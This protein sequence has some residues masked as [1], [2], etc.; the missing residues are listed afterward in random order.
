MHDEHGEGDMHPPSVE[1]FRSFLLSTWGRTAFLTLTLAGRPVAIAVSDM[2]PDGLSAI[3][4]FFDPDLEPRG[5]GTYAVLR[6]IQL[7][8]ERHL[9]YLYLGYW[10]RDCEKMSYK[11]DFRPAEL[12]V[13]N[14]W[15]VMN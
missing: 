5:L 15:V 1:Q 7:C 14:R 12:F 11:I 13:N 10:I 9:D 2:L 6:Q 4:T 8:Q 3:Y